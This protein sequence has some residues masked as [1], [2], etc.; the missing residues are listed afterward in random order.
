MTIDPLYGATGTLGMQRC[1]AHETV[2]VLRIEHKARGPSIPNVATR[3]ATLEV[4]FLRVPPES[5]FFLHLERESRHATLETALPVR[6]SSLVLRVTSACSAA[7]R[8]C[9]ELPAVARTPCTT[10]ISASHAIAS[11]PSCRRRH[12]DAPSRSVA[13]TRH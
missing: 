3:L 1:C 13:H 8:K 7:D 6:L 5:E 2:A 4:A 10:R 9:K 12:P 11:H